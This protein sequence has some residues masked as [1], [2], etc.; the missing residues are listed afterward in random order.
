MFPAAVMMEMLIYMAENQASG[1][2]AAYE[3]LEKHP[4]VWTQWVTPQGAAL[5]KRAL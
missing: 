5:I 2:D 3:F 1:E 4:D